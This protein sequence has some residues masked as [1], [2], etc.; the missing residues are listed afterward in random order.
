[1]RVGLAEIRNIFAP[2]GRLSR[3]IVNYEARP[4]QVQF[5]EEVLST[6]EE[7]GY[8]VAEAATGVGKSLGYLV[9]SLVVSLSRDSRVV[10]STNTKNL[11]EQLV[12]KDLPVLRQV[13]GK[14]FSAVALKGRGNYLCL[15]KWRELAAPESDERTS[16]FMQ[17]VKAG[18]ELFPS[19]D[20]GEAASSFNYALWEQVQSDSSTC[21]FAACSHTN[22]C[23]W[24][25][26]RR[27]AAQA[28]IVIVNH[29]LLFS[30]VTCGKTVLPEYDTVIMDEAHN[31]ERVASEHFGVEVTLERV[32]KEGGRLLSGRGVLASVRRKLPR[33]LPRLR[34]L[35]F[36]SRAQDIEK[37][38]DEVFSLS[39]RAFSK[40]SERLS[41][42][43]PVIAVRLGGEGSSLPG[44]FQELA[45]ASSRVEELL[46]GLL[47]LV[48]ENAELI[49]EPEGLLVEVAGAIERWRVLSGNLMFLWEGASSDYVYWV[50]RKFDDELALKACPVWVRDEIREN[51][52]SCLRAAVLTSATMAVAGNLG[53]FV[54]RLGL[55]GAYEPSCVVIDSPFDYS[56]QV[57]VTVPRDFPDPRTGTFPSAASELITG[58]L[59]TVP[60]K[61]MVLFTAYDM[62]RRVHDSVSQELS[63]EGFLVLGQGVDGSRSEIMDRFKS[64]SKAVLMGTSSFWEGV[65][66][67]GEALE[68]LVLVRLPFPVP[69]DPLVLARSEALLEE[70]KEPFTDYL[71]PEA[72]IRL[73][74]GFGRLIRRRSDRG[75]VVIIDPRISRA[76]YGPVFLKSLPTAVEPC[77]TEALPASVFDW[78]E[79]LEGRHA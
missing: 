29:S 14:D 66:L 17:V 70:G 31:V 79:R 46:N 51:L 57:A 61:T 71:L 52:F 2:G 10:I 58:L 43:G 22:E 21:M 77:L 20:V 45:L 4:Q 13:F 32:R 36:S 44:E 26:S 65:D 1:L 74:Q 76:S 64:S 28:N 30:D 48:R 15:R 7:G 33:G 42:L 40:L 18:L 68:I 75:A 50:E 27:S 35:S 41:S 24:R 54:F 78:F 63:S 73:R 59:R 55:E 23:Y 3:T 19:G 60:R 9:P 5:A 16:D 53:H 67:P 8:L 62:L 25:R 6:L 12:D 72:V 38:S 34:R 56:R 37:A 49:K 11:Q 47:L 39:E 69:D